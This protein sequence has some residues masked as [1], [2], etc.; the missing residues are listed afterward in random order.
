MNQ[1]DLNDVAARIASAAA[2]F[3]PSHR[4]TALQ[5]ADAASVLHGI[6]QAA[7]QHG[8]RFADF[9][10]VADFPRLAIQLVQSRDERR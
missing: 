10:G 3:A 6:L 8:V 4:P 5:V 7:E 2:E 9:D 1:H